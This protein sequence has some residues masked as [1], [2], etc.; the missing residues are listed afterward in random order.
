MDIKKLMH[1]LLNH[2]MFIEVM[3]YLYDNQWFE[4]Q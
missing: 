1:M 4:S 2:Y 3:R